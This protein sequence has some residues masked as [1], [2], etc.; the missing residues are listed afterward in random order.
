MEEL[1]TVQH[2]SSRA[3]I[4]MH[5]L[6]AIVD[7]ALRLCL[8]VFLS[9]RSPLQHV[10]A[11]LQSLAPGLRQYTEMLAAPGGSLLH[12]GD[13]VCAPRLRACAPMHTGVH[14]GKL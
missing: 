1:C 10:H 14:A 2:P 11:W 6:R 13:E 7:V 12:W 9:V 3:P 4:Q 5:G 8:D